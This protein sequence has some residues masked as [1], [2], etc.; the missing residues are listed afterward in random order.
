MG[1]RVREVEE[2]PIKQGVDEEIAY[3]FNWK[4]I[5]IPNMPIVEIYDITNNEYT[6]TTSTNLSGEASIEDEQYVITP[7]VKSL[8]NKRHYRLECRVFI[9]ENTMETYCHII[10]EL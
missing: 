2:S 8:V 3:K 6:D 1:N 7:V 9:N 10:G 5:G 4:K